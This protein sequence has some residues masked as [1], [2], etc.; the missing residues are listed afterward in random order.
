METGF[1]GKRGKYVIFLMSV[2]KSLIRDFVFPKERRKFLRFGTLYMICIT[3]VFLYSCVHFYVLCTSQKQ[4][5]K[6]EKFRKHKKLTFSR[7]S[8]ELGLGLWTS[9]YMSLIPY[10]F[11]SR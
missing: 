7:V 6:R 9:I 4:Y 1:I 11:S 2:R 5:Q 8:N 3:C 10:F